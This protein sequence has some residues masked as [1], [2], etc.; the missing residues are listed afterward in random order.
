MHQ[1]EPFYNWRSLYVANEDEKSPFFKHYNNEVFFEHAIYN[2]YIHPQWDYFGSQTLYAKLLYTN[3]ETGYAIIELFGEW[4][5]VLY[6]DIMYFY[7]NVIEILLEAGIRYFILLGENVLNFHSEDTDY[8]EEW[9][10]NLDDGWIVGINFSEHVRN[11]FSES[12]ID[13]Y[14]GFGGTFNEM[15]WRTLFP[16]QLFEWINAAMNKRLQM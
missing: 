8:Y 11:E 15:A 10:E 12:S 4:N 1:I 5:D 13:Q 6:N 14:V 16:D 7:R 2:H 3:Y 9:F